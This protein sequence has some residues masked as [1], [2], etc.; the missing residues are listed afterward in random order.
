MAYDK[1]TR[2]T[3]AE[4]TMTLVMHV[5]FSHQ[6]SIYKKSL[7]Y[8]SCLA[9]YNM[10]YENEGSLDSDSKIE[11]KNIMSALRNDEES[12]DEELKFVIHKLTP[13]F[14]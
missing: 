12:W 4:K 1:D 13:I 5:M 8:N 14:T 6:N 9:I 2:E 7:I 3:I 11:Y 10:I